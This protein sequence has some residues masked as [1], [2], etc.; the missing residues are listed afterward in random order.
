MSI[1]SY[2]CAYIYINRNDSK[3][4]KL[5]NLIFT[6]ERQTYCEHLELINSTVYNPLVVLLFLLGTIMISITFSGLVK[7]DYRYIIFNSTIFYLTESVYIC[8]R[9]L[10]P[11]FFIF[12]D[13]VLEYMFLKLISDNAS[14]TCVLL[15]LHRFIIIYFADFH[16]LYV[17]KRVVWVVIFVFDFFLLVTY[18]LA[19]LFSNLHLT[20][21]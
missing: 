14:I 10:F 20:Q 1:N 16:S 9:A 17:N 19:A 15:S 5:E 2:T 4:S 8:I 7:E 21:S 13:L 6:R 18:Y 3:Y 12:K 11:S